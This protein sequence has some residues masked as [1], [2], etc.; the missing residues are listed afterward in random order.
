[1]YEIDYICFKGENVHILNKGNIIASTLDEGVK[2]HIFIYERPLN[3]SNYKLNQ[4]VIFDK[5]EKKWP[6]IGLALLSNE[7]LITSGRRFIYIFNKDENSKY[8]IYQEFWEEKWA[9][10][11]NIKEL[12]NIPDHFAVCG[13]YGLFIF[14]KKNDKYEITFE[15]DYHR[16]GESRISDFM[17]IKGKEKAFIIC[18]TQNILIT[19]NKNIL[20]KIYFHEDDKKYWFHNDY[21]C[22]FNDEL[23]LVSG[24][25][26]I[27]FVNTNKNTFK[28][29][30]FLNHKK[31]KFVDSTL[32]YKYDNN[33]IILL[34][35]KEIFIIQIF[36]DERIQ[37]N[38]TFYLED[39]YYS[40]IKFIQ[41]EKC[42]YFLNKYSISKLT[43]NKKMKYS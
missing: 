31:D 26:Y 10:M 9:E 8:H 40:F 6:I 37:I 34:C 22:E 27:T 32:I 36:G 25:R 20:N 14:S 12:K 35:E 43:F 21:I 19:S 23:F 39:V 7:M 33:T 28:Q 41:E 2:N 3:Q 17:E 38:M 11:M 15:L 16:L 30:N 13:F 5:S 1:M 42:V 24:Q 18:S 4:E 29:I